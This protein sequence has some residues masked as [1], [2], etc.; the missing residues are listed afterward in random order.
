MEVVYEGKDINYMIR[1][2]EEDLEKHEYI[3]SLSRIPEPS[4]GRRYRQVLLQT[5]SLL[6]SLNASVVIEFKDG[7]IRRYVFIGKVIPRES[8]D[9]FIDMPFYA[10][11]YI[12]ET[13]GENQVYRIFNP[14]IYPKARDVFKII[15]DIGDKF[16]LSDLEVHMEKITESLD[17]DFL[18]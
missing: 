6:G 4:R 2:L 3:K 8:S 7:L 5:F 13:W 1:L 10:D 12:F 16:R 11:G 14:Y 15:R 18:I 17:F 9:S